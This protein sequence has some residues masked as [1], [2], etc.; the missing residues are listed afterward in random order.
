MRILAGLQL[1]TEL[2]RLGLR[3]GLIIGF[4]LLKR[5]QQLRVFLR[6][7]G[8]LELPQLVLAVQ[9][10]VIRRQGE[11]KV[12]QILCIRMAFRYWRNSL[13]PLV[14]QMPQGLALMQGLQSLQVLSVQQDSLRRRLQTLVERVHSQVLV[15]PLQQPPLQ[16]ALEPQPLV[17]QLLRLRYQLR[18][19]PQSRPL[20]LQLELLVPRLQL[21]PPLLRPTQRLPLEVPVG[22]PL[23]QLMVQQLTPQHSDQPLPQQ[24]QLPEH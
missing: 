14:I 8:L 21:L 22:L 7:Q 17:P 15:V 24:S 3:A 4:K 6:M 2:L 12:T 13:L 16:R 18:P 9:R 23:P 11:P 19:R 20:A 10:W 1:M 5:F